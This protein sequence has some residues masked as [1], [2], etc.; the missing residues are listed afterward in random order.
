MKKSLAMGKSYDLTNE[1]INEIIT[2]KSAG[3]YAYGNIKNDTFMVSYVG[4]SD[5][6]G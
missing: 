1:K 3:N 4:R 5:T 2:K 6:S